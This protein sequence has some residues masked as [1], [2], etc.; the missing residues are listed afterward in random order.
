MISLHEKNIFIIDIKTQSGCET[1]WSAIESYS[2]QMIPS[3]QNDEFLF[4]DSKD[5]ILSSMNVPSIN[6]CY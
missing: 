4:I 1:L 3:V 6:N 5:T 2:N